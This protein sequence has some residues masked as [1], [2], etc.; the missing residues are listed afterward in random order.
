MLHKKFV[1]KSL[2][3]LFAGLM[4]I[5]PNIT[6]HAEEEEEIIIYQQEEEPEPQKEEPVQQPVYPPVQQ[7]V[8]PMEPQ[9]SEPVK[10]S[11]PVQKKA[12]P[13]PTVEVSPTVTPSPSPTVTPTPEITINQGVEIEAD[14]IPKELEGSQWTE[15]GN[16][17]VRWFNVNATTTRL[18]IFHTK[19]TKEIEFAFKDSK[20]N[21]VSATDESITLIPDNELEYTD[22]VYDIIYI[23]EP[24]NSGEWSISIKKWKDTKE[25]FLVLSEIPQEWK[26]E[27]Y[28]KT[29]P[30]SV[31]CWYLDEKSEYKPK[32]ILN[33]IKA[34]IIPEDYESEKTIET[35]GEIDPVKVI[36]LVSIIIIA[37][38]AFLLFKRYRANQEYDRLEREE[39]ARK[40]GSKHIFSEEEDYERI[41]EKMSE[42]FEDEDFSDDEYYNEL[43]SV[44][45]KDEEISELDDE[46]EENMYEKESESEEVA[47][48]APLNENQYD[49]DDEYEIYSEDEEYQDD[50]EKEI[51]SN[52]E[53]T[54]NEDTPD[55]KEPESENPGYGFLNTQVKSNKNQFF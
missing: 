23:N 40:R 12:T 11:K 52:N 10:K 48:D 3:V 21:N 36:G 25:L 8:Q 30:I 51:F 22:L 29:K 20:G 15:T 39:G 5:T 37:V 28:F 32:D 9:Q 26:M 14:A 53:D 13:T 35:K 55:K 18:E 7:S 44:Q 50:T 41:K 47:D 31:L 1:Q 34:D 6:S 24:E 16:T 45:E 38:I 17:A 43:N 4:C 49:F 46:S 54:P 19:D 42:I 2:L 27:K 33:I